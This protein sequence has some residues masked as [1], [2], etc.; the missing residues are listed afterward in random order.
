MPKKEEKRR[1]I[2]DKE[3]S[4]NIKKLI[5]YLFLTDKELATRARR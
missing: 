2:T 4:R 1:Y 5:S 3:H